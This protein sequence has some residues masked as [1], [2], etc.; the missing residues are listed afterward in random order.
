[1]GEM[2]FASEAVS[3]TFAGFF[4]YAFMR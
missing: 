2:R 3:R 4:A 1:V